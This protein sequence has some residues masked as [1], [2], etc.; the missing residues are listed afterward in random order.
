[1]IR[2]TLTIAAPFLLGAAAQVIAQGAHLP[3]VTLHLLHLR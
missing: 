1:M 2:I 3:A